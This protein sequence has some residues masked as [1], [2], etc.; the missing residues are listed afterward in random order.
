MASESESDD[1]DNFA[2][3]EVQVEGEGGTFVYDGWELRFRGHGYAR[4]IAPF[5]PRGP[6]ERAEDSKQSRQQLH[7]TTQPQEW[8][9]AQCVFRGLNSD[10]TVEELQDTLRGHE[11]DAMAKDVLDVL[12][13]AKRKFRRL[14]RAAREDNWKN[15]MSPDEKATLDPERFLKETFPASSRSREIVLLSTHFVGTIQETAEE[16]GLCCEYT[17]AP[18]SGNAVLQM[19]K[20]WV[21]IGRH[22]RTVTERVQMIERET[23]R[24]KQE[25][26]EGMQELRRKNLPVDEGRSM[27]M[28]RDWDVTGTW[29]ISCPQIEDGWGV[30]NLTLRIYTS[31]LTEGSQMFAQF[32]FKTVTGV[33]RFERQEDDT[34]IATSTTI[35]H[36]DNDDHDSRESE[37]TYEEDDAGKSNNQVQSAMQSY[38]DDHDS[39][40]SDDTYEEDAGPSNNP[41]YTTHEDT[42][43]PDSN[44][45]RRSP[46]PEAF[47]LSETVQPSP[48]HRTWHYRYRGEDASG[49]V[50]DDDL[51]TIT[52]G[53]SQGRTL[54][55]TFGGGAFGDCDFT[56]VK[57]AI[58]RDIGLD[59]REEWAKR[60]A[61][62]YGH[63]NTGTG[64]W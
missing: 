35:Y 22:R 51:Y 31:Q 52:F 60:D 21:V 50:S 17:H 33:F 41:D 3:G 20:Y 47:Y 32:D 10:G 63:E 4:R 18:S 49:L 40:D 57:V 61:S 48:K 25:R 29:A 7:Y 55:G 8:W 9:E 44:E 36:N 26:Q 58:G 12:G 42:S 56:G 45:Q 28:S 38:N 27:V 64:W 30:E 19:A 62:A 43:S 59:I 23:Q 2:I 24:L 6:S 14:N 54:E 1:A 15:N 5:I 34:G 46:T 53:G 13:Q 16:L 39:P 37:N 11:E